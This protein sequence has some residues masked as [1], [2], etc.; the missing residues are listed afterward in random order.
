MDRYG[1]QR[2]GHD[3]RHQ[4]TQGGRNCALSR[5][6]SLA[7]IRL[8]DGFGE[9][10]SG[11]NC[12]LLG[13]NDNLIKLSEASQRLDPELA[14]TKRTVRKRKRHPDSDADEGLNAV[15]STSFQVKRQKETNIDI[16][17]SSDASARKAG[18]TSSSVHIAE[19]IRRRTLHVES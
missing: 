6:T 2:S 7:D 11:L 13:A 19:G 16:A 10:Q 5:D 3:E 12:Q 14:T 9:V 17:D 15:D 18:S 8:L 4:S 1:A